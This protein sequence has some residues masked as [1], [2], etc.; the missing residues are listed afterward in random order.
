[1]LVLSL[2]SSQVRQLPT[3]AHTS[4][5]PVP[6]QP[7]L[8]LASQGSPAPRGARGCNVTGPNVGSEPGSHCSELMNKF[9]YKLFSIRIL[10]NSYLMRDTPKPMSINL[11]GS[12]V[13]KR[14]ITGLD[15]GN[16]AYQ[17]STN[18]CVM[19]GNSL[20]LSKPTSLFNS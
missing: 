7:T 11:F 5:W 14:N 16:L 12:K 1:M 10:F 8:L 17:F 9:L 15:L 2:R 4:R 20:N 6:L 3:A 13:N 18:N 19:M